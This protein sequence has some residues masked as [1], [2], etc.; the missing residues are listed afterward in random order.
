MERVERDPTSVAS[1]TSRFFGTKH[2][3][4]NHSFLCVNLVL[5]FDSS[6]PLSLSSLACNRFE[7]A[8]K[9]ICIDWAT[10]VKKNYIPHF[11]FIT[12]HSNANLRWSLCSK[13]IICRFRLFTP[14]TPSR[15]LLVLIPT[16][17][18]FFLKAYLERTSG[19]SVLGLE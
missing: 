6:S 14:L 11:D 3:E 17:C 19:L 16:R 1:S 13:F 8:P 2:R 9:V 18:I 15:W 5:R 12:S 4:I 10:H 7:L